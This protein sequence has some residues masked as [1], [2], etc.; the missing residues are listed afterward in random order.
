MDESAYKG[1]ER[2]E[3]WVHYEGKVSKEV[4]FRCTPHSADSVYFPRIGY[5]IHQDYVYSNRERAVEEASRW[6]FERERELAGLKR[7]LREVQ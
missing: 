6:I 3:G 7:K 2:I 4:G 1:R 5:S